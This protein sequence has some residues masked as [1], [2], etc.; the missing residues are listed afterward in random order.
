MQRRVKIYKTVILLIVLISVG[1]LGYSLIEGMSFTDAAYMTV[2]TM[3]TVGFRE[4]ADLSQGGKLF[5]IFFIVGSLGTAAYAFS[6]ISYFLLEGELNKAIRRR[7]ME[8]DVSNLK[9]HYIVCGYGQTGQIVVEQ[10]R[11]KNVPFVVIEQDEEKVAEL[12]EQ[13]IL[14]LV[15]D[16][17]TEE[18][19]EKARI[20][21]SRGLIA[22]L[23]TDAD[24]VFTVLTAREMNPE[25]YIVARA[26]DRAAHSKLRKAGANNTISPNELGGTRMAALVLK[27][28]VVSFIDVVT[29][30]GDVD[31]DIEQ[32]IIP[33]GSPGPGKP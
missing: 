2:I 8:R 21:H 23:A 9:D 1:I 17:S 7:R 28:A 4:V 11:S 29:R 12:C 6:S 14:A 5:T 32:V 26:I 20:K 19:L 15:G 24:N 31:F 10:F 33:A 27:P 25:L 18:E 13:G 16:A 3:S 22:S 30:V